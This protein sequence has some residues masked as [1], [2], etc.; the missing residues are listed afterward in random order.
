MKHNPAADA[1]IGKALDNP[2]T[3]DWEIEDGQQVFT[4]RPHFFDKVNPKDLATYF[5]EYGKGK[6]F[7][8]LL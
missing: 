1:E 7:L 5:A 4:P 2:D 6:Q 8:K 3:G